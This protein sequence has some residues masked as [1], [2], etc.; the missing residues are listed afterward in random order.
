MRTRPI[1][2]RRRLSNP[3]P[4]PSGWGSHLLL[5]WEFPLVQ[6]EESGGGEHIFLGLLLRGQCAWGS[7][8]SSG[9]LGSPPR[10]ALQSAGG[11]DDSQPAGPHRQG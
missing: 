10:L 1:G 7:V 11:W 5:P 6:E 2:P 9:G 4:A 3:A 8:F